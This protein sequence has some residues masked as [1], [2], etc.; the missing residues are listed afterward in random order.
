MISIT[1]NII[2]HAFAAAIFE[3]FTMLNRHE[4]IHISHNTDF[5]D[6]LIQ[7]EMRDGTTIP[8]SI[9]VYDG[10]MTFELVFDIESIYD[11]KQRTAFTAIFHELPVDEEAAA[12][13]SVSE[14]N[15]VYAGYTIGIPRDFASALISKLS[16]RYYTNTSPVEHTISCQFWG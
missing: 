16:A 6:E 2:P 1:I 8:T 12:E 13:L 14:E 10:D 15:G 7:N 3:H 11:N 9:E 4:L 5:D